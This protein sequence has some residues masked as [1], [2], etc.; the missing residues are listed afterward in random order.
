MNDLRKCSICLVSGLLVAACAAPLDE[1]LESGTAEERHGDAQEDGTDTA[2][3]EENIASESSEL[4]AEGFAHGQGD[5]TFS[6]GRYAR[7]DMRDNWHCRR[8]HRGW[9]WVRIRGDYDRDQQWGRDNGWNRD[10]RCCIRVQVP[11][12]PHG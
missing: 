12:R 7:C 1:D 2:D 6:G 4:T 9:R 10:R 5:H 11:H 3:A 8:G